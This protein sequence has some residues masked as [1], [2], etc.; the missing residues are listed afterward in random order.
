M[1]TLKILCQCRRMPGV[2]DLRLL[3]VGCLSTQATVELSKIRNIGIIAH[4]D[5]GKT[6]TTERMLYYSGFTQTMG[7][8]HDGDTVTDY[9]PQE[10]ERGITITAATITFP[11]KGHAINLIDTPGHVDFTV[12]V[13][14]SLRVLDGAVTILDASAGV[15]AQTMTVWRQADYYRL[16]RLIYL[17]K[18]DK[19]RAD[20]NACLCDIEQKLRIR[21]LICQLPV[22]N[23]NT[24]HFCGM[25]DLV[26]MQEFVWD[27]NDASK[28]SRFQTIPGEYSQM[29]NNALA[30]RSQLIEDLGAIDDAFAERFV[31]STAEPTAADIKDAIRKATRCKA[32]IPLFCGSSY[33]NIGVQLLLDAIVNYLPDPSFAVPKEVCKF[34][35]EKDTVAMAFKI[36]HTKFKGPL[37]FVR[38]YSGQLDAGQRIYIMNREINEKCGELLQVNA[39]E[40]VP[41]QQ[42]GQGSIVAIS[43][44]KYTTTGDTIVGLGS[45]GSFVVNK[46]STLKKNAILFEFQPP[47]P[48]YQCR[49]EASSLGQQKQ[50]EHALKC[51]QREDPSLVVIH[52]ES[53]GEIQIA[54]MG[55]LHIEIVRDRIKR[56]F[57]V[58]PHLGPLQIAYR[59]RLSQSIAGLMHV[60]D[61]TLAGH[62]HYVEVG[63]DI[64]KIPKTDKKEP[65]MKLHVTD[66]NGLG[67]IRSFHFKALENG[68]KLTLAHGPI[69]GFPLSG[70]QVVLN[71]FVVANSTSL[72]MVT[73]AMAQCIQNGLKSSSEVVELMEP[74]MELEISVP[75]EY[76]G[77]TLSDLSRRRAQIKNIGERTGN[78]IIFAKCPLSELRHY[79]T[80]LRTLTSGRATFIM[81][82]DTYEAMSTAETSALLRKAAGLQ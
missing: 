15:E 58:E 28:G 35:S 2:R 44:L 64:R 22:I 24:G 4:I 66:E 79:S 77:K 49:I 52:Q 19:D 69:L 31:L 43:G 62:K 36:V 61:K 10:R 21:P 57:K 60:L 39:D 7:E 71:H 67:K 65:L 25:F 23:P 37:T 6:T 72:P 27:P 73:A 80:E 70:A 30:M 13:E 48:V 55:E 40:Y 38:I 42:A 12:E 78:R 59:E 56:E 82:L 3:R 41:I 75:N 18:M 46:D 5:A 20:F 14:R 81:E 47:D 11:W 26:R 63:L 16:P 33:K 54:G 76:L 51:L 8:V 9:M 53:T 17:N 45:T 74:H 50:L 32:V 34:Y 29:L 68:V 1:L